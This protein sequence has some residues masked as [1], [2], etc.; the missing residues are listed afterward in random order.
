M[1]AEQLAE[2]EHVLHDATRLVARSNSQEAYDLMMRALSITWRMQQGADVKVPQ[3]TRSTSG[4]MKGAGRAKTED[5]SSIEQDEVRKV[6][7][8][9]KLWQKRP[10]QINSQI[11]SAFLKIQRARNKPVSEK[12]LRACFPLDFPFDSNFAQMR[13]IAPKNHGKVFDL[14]D[15]VVSIWP[16]V[17]EYVQRFQRPDTLLK[18][19]AR[20]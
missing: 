20:N 4:T 5:R 14:T 9:L 18:S 8:R 10:T 2:L 11:L 3:D 19:Q 7:K 15:D 12:E 16:P 1:S 6:E 13:L 17:A